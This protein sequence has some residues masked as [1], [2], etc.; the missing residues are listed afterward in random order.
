MSN[1]GLKIR[2]ENEQQVVD[3]MTR[4]HDW[5]ANELDIDSKME[6]GRTCNWGKDAFHAGLWYN[7]TK[8]SVLNFRNLYG[9][10]M[11]QML[12]IVAHEARHAVQGKTGMIDWTKDRRVKT[13]HNGRWESGTWNGEY[14]SGPY[15]DAPWEVDARAHE[16]EYAQLVIDAGIITQEE[17][18]GLKQANNAFQQLSVVGR[19]QMR[20]EFSKTGGKN[21]YGQDLFENDDEKQ[22]IFNKLGFFDTELS[23]NEVRANSIIYAIARARKSSGRLNLDDIER[24]AKDLNIFGMTSSASVVSKL[25]FLEQELLSK[26]NAAYTSLG[27]LAAANPNMLGAFNEMKNLGYGSYSEERIRGLGQANPDNSV[28]QGPKLKFGFDPTTGAA[29]QLPE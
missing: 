23:A 1:I 6:F 3:I 17:F 18:D 24:A 9:A 14:W 11:Y 29:V 21:K 2:N 26:R 5:L 8:H 7:S 22:A 12:K 19:A 25:G 13:L 16:E 20:A 28:P 4:C 15:R 27:V 10:N